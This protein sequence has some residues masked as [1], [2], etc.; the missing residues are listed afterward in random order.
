VKRMRNIAVVLAASVTM[1]VAPA[2][3]AFASEGGDRLSLIDASC[4][5]NGLLSGVLGAPA[6]NLIGGIAGAQHASTNQEIK[7]IC[8][9][10]IVKDDD[11]EDKPVY[12]KHDN[13][14]PVY[15][16]HDNEKPVYVKHDDEKV[17]EK[18][19]VVVVKPDADDADDDEHDKC[20]SRRCAK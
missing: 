9:S 6:I 17:D 3:G 5:G 2:S 8:N 16:K 20:F 7:N 19:H 15:F 1:I 10:V 12:F 18:V 14:K 13:E 11:K 4:L